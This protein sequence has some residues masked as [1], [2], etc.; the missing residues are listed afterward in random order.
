MNPTAKGTPGPSHASQELHTLTATGT[1]VSVWVARLPL[2]TSPRA[3]LERVASLGPAPLRSPPGSAALE[4]L[5]DK[6]QGGRRH[7]TRDLSGGGAGGA[8]GALSSSPLFVSGCQH[9]GV[10]VHSAL[11]ALSTQPGPPRKLS[12]VPQPYPKALLPALPSPSPAR[13]GWMGLWNTCGWTGGGGES[14]GRGP[15]P[16]LPVQRCSQHTPPAATPP[17]LAGSPKQVKFQGRDQERSTMPFADA[18]SKWAIRS[19]W[20]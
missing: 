8:D 17:P 5:R 12:N 16:T 7:D 1:A 13:Q 6:A 3:P 19:G 18:H 9:L 11:R 10:S 2:P 14:G 4:P 20:K 15:R